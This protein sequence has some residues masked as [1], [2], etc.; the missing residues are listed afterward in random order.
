MMVAE[1]MPVAKVQEHYLKLYEEIAIRSGP[2]EQNSKRVGTTIPV[3]S[4]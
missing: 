4:L 3:L 1:A 2:K